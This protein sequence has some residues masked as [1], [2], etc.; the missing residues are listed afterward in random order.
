MGILFVLLSI[1]L[2]SVRLPLAV[3]GMIPVSFIGVFLSFGLS[4]F[5][6]DQGGYASFVMLSGIVVN[7]GI[8]VTTAY[9]QLGGMQ[10]T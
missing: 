3:I 5:S 8:Y 4:D 9:K 7:A 10:R 2:E 1:S 6:F